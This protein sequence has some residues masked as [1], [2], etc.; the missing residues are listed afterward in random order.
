MAVNGVNDFPKPG[1]L[2]VDEQEGSRSNPSL[3]GLHVKALAL[4]SGEEACRPVTLP[5]H[6]AC[7]S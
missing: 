4:E 6:C 7:L 1:E 3:S 5:E 2:S